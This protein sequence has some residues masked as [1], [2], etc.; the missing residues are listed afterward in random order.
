MV[1]KCEQ[2]GLLLWIISGFFS[3][4]FVL[5]V[6][7]LW[8]KTIPFGTFEF[9]KKQ[10][11]F[12]GIIASWPIFVWGCGVTLIHAFF[13]RNRPDVNRNAESLLIGGA[14]VSIIAGV[15]E[16]MIFRWTI[17]L[18]GIVAIKV[19]NFLFFGFL[20]FGIPE[21]FQVNIS[22]PVVNFLTLGKM[23]WLVIDMGWVVG[24]ATI[25]ANAKF[26]AEHAYLGP[27]GLV[28]SWII[29]FF[30][31]WVMFNYGL[32]TSIIVH[33]LYD[34][35]IYIVKYVDAAIERERGFV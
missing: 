19:S 16:E 29:G 17:F 26:R 13:T 25:A 1:M 21:W 4:L 22:G 9:W 20:G 11:I 32:L 27:F 10:Q 5:V 14:V 6:Q 33:F 12:E 30:L 24:A 23:K 34:M 3:F 7:W 2:K 8:P 15:F 28:N 31:F 35:F 18:S